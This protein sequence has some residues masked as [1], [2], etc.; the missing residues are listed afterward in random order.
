MTCS[1]PTSVQTLVKLSSE[2]PSIRAWQVNYH[3]NDDD[4]SFN[5]SNAPLNDVWALCK[6]TLKVTS[7]DTYTDSNTRERRAYEADG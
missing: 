7:L 5:S 2:Q 4:S 1:R 6:N 3:W